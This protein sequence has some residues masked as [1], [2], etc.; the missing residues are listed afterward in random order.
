MERTS[1]TSFAGLPTADDNVFGDDTAAEIAVMT[2]ALSG[3]AALG[4]AGSLVVSV[5]RI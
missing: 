5:P 2:P 1:L 4:Y 3:S